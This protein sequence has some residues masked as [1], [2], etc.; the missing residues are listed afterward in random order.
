MIFK[1]LRYIILFC[2]T[3]YG[4]LEQDILYAQTSY[5]L[6]GYVSD[7][8]NGEM[9][10]G[11]TVRVRGKQYTGTVTNKFGYYTLKLPAG[12]YILSITYLGYDQK[13]DTLVLSHSVHI[14]YQ[15]KES[16]FEKKEV[17]VTDARK[18]ENV[19]GTAMGEVK[20]SMKEVKE[21][22]AMFGE[23]DILKTL[24]MLPGVKSGGEGT[25]D[26]FIRG[27]G[28]GQNLVL[29]DDAPVYNTGHLFGFFSVF[30]GDAVKDVNLIKGGMPANYGGRLSSVV[31]VK[32]KEGNNK[33]L[34]GA[35]GVGLVSSRFSLEGPIVKNK[36][37]FF[38]S[39]RRTYIDALMQPFVS[40]SSS[41]YGSGYY[42]YDINLKAN[43]SLS[44]KDRLFLS[45]YLGKD[46]FKFQSGDQDFKMNMPW[47]NK[48]ATLRW[49]H[50]FS[51]RLFLNTELIYNDYNFKLDGEQKSLL[52]RMH[53][54]IRDLTFK[55]HL[56]YYINNRHHLKL[57][58]IYTYHTFIPSTV[59]GSSNKI[60]FDAENPFTKYGRE[61]ALYVMDKWQLTSRF[62]V[63]A[64]VR[65][66]LFQQVGPYTQYQ[67]DHQGEKIDSTSYAGGKPVATYSSWEPRLILQ[68]GLEHHNSL[69]ASVT[70]NSQYIHL[71]TSN[72]TTLPTDL[73]VPSTKMVKP[74][75]SWQYSLGY[76]QNFK[77]NT[78]ETSLAVYYKKMDHQIEFSASYVPSSL[79][80]PQNHFVF[81]EAEAYGAELFIRKQKGRLKGWLGYTLSWVFRDFPKLNE[82]IRYPARQDRRHDLKVVASYRLN[83]KWTLA[84][85]FILQSGHPITLPEQ[86]YVM[87]GT[88]SQ[89]YVHLNTYRLPTYHRL[90]LSATYTP[91]PKPDRSFSHYWTF[92][93]YNAYSR[94]NPFFI[95]FDTEGDY[96]E[97]KMKIQPKKVALFPI[98]PS[99]SWNFKF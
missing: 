61:L 86:F 19:S 15:L 45:G 23:T 44:D 73:W 14:N 38:V 76:Y 28:P 75:R 66:G 98:I 62:K 81:G 42:F 24:Q 97:G 59:S 94:L 8:V 35:G 55:T 39:A 54:G 26:L 30:N 46:H 95:Y 63:N 78:F 77:E 91:P 70:R 52:M 17:I 92:S 37:S 96:L 2:L 11:A 22:P 79:D 4:V 7:A 71:V 10:D 25:S 32:M 6:S 82:G 90:D 9:L 80:E 47:G 40:K 3:L 21:L 27:G 33:E 50:L 31:D 18:D 74:E 72:S 36:A 29:L 85:N 41:F 12:E 99:I 53:S 88:L 64:G 51:D 83:K 57:G 65:W 5:S 60:D 89:E 43:Y 48:T 87:E 34:H 1:R 69:K 13:T 67:R 93:L 49:N 68:Y 16:A 20:L 56:S 84:A 58:G